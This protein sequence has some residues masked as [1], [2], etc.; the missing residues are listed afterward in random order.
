MKRV[1]SE[2]NYELRLKITDVILS[3]LLL[4]KHNRP[5]TM[6]L[7]LTTTYGRLFSLSLS[8]AT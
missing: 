6:S 8:L 4:N 1:I 5:C 3:F 7:S 2:N